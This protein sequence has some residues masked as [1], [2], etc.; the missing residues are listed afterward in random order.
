MEYITTAAG[1][2]GTGRPVVC[3]TLALNY[4]VSGLDPWSY[5]VANL[6]IHASAALVLFGIVRRTLQGPRLR[7]R[8]GTQ[9]NGLAVAVAVCWAVHPLQTE[10]VTYI[11]QRVESLMGLFLLLTLYCVIRG[12]HSPRRFGGNGGSSD[13]LR[14]GD[15]QQGRNGNCAHHCAAV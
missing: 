12:H 14:T 1:R 5:H 3:L 10:S 4:A 13:L 8:F 9:A 6:A 7:D 11:I 2:T 15:G